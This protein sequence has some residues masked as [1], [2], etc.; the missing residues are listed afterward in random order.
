MNDDKLIDTIKTLKF[1]KG[2]ILIVKLKEK[3][4]MVM[5]EMLR[6]EFKRVIPKDLEVKVIFSNPDVEFEILRRVNNNPGTKQ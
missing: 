3:A 6:K 2:D 4:P 1:E 5:I